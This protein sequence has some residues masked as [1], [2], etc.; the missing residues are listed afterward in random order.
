ERASDHCSSIAVLMLARNNEDILG[1]HYDYLRQLHE[2]TDKHY[3]SE[4]R[5]RREQYVDQLYHL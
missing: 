3:S 2:G 1:N 5:R 4:L